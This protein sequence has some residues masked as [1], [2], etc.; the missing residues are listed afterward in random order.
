[1]CGDNGCAQCTGDAFVLEKLFCITQ[2]LYLGVH[3][4]GVFDWGSCCFLI[5][6]RARQLFY[7]IEEKEKEVENVLEKVQSLSENMFTAGTKLTSI[8]ENESSRLR[9]LQ[10]Q[11]RILQRAAMC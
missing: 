3:I 5:V 7:D 4:T 1:M 11:A 8:S 6:K 2:S 10:L 9:N